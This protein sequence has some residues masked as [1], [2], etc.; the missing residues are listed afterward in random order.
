[1]AR[2]TRRRVRVA[3]TSEPR[4]TFE[5]VERETP[6]SSATSPSVARRL[7]R[8]MRDP[9]AGGARRAARAGLGVRGRIEERCTGDDA[10]LW[11]DEAVFV[12][13][14]EVRGAGPGLQGGDERR[15]PA[16]V[17]LAL[18]DR[19][20]VPPDRRWVARPAAVKQAVEAQLRR[21]VADVLGVAPTDETAETLGHRERVHALPEQV[22]RIEVDGDRR[23]LRSGA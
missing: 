17:V 12:L 3:T 1:M 9:L 4:T 2:R 18:P 20:E 23:C 13:D 11:R 15:P 14:A 10:G 7:L 5:T 6:A 19:R 21:V 8:S 22:A 16:D